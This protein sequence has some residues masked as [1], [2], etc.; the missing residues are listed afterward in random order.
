MKILPRISERCPIKKEYV[1]NITML[2]M[3]VPEISNFHTLTCYF[4]SIAELGKFD[5]V[6]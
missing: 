1:H 5:H 4:F 3:T 2:Y 6:S